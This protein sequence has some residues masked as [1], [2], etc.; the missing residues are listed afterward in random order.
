MPAL[1][2]VRVA[3]GAKLDLRFTGTKKVEKVRLGGRPRSGLISAET[4]P[5]Y[6][7]GPG[8]LW[9]EPKGMTILIR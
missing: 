4:D 8:E 3:A 5:E 2:G 7:S 9:V 1:D 6:L